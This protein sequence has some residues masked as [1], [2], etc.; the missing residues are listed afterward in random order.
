MPT[1]FVT[2]ATGFIGRH[3][4]ERLLAARGRR[5][6]CS[7]ARAR[8]RSSTRSSRGSAA[9][10]RIQAV[11]GRP[12]R[13][14]CSA[15]PRPTRDGAARQR[16]P[17]LPPR[18]DLRHDRRRGRSNALLNVDGTQHA[19]DARQRP[20]RRA[21]STTPPRSPSPATYQGHFTEDMFDEGQPLP[22]AVPPDEVRV[23][24]ARPRAGR[25]APGAS[26]GR[27]SWSATRARAR[28]TRSTA[29]TTSSRRSRRSRHALPEWFPLVGLEVGWTNIVPVDF[30]AAAM[31]HIAHEP[32]ARRPGVPPR[33]PAPAA[34]RRRAQ[35]VR[36]RRPRAADGHARRQ[37]D[38][39]HA[40][41][42]RPVLRDEAA[43]AQG[44]PAHAARR[45]RHPRRGARAHGA[46]PALRRA[47]HAA[48]AR[49]HR[50]RGA[51]A[52]DLRRRS[53]GTTGSA[54]S[55]PTCSRTA[56][57]RARSTARRS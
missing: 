26:T 52:R 40:A 42:G 53:C 33:Q 49:G 20:R 50:H 47:R 30:V 51:A 18:R 43:G 38:D 39:G 34:R 25:R 19:V 23:R 31:D 32:A 24:E 8:A 37:A 56:R 4:L 5:S 10:D 12:G 3:L 9:S 15:S 16:R 35:H 2:G 1:Y 17:L 7:C 6:T 36:A 22:I 48:R 41:E 14:R 45:P 55:T 54:T 28:W 44:R 21:S 29:R 27:R 46:R 13:S 57:S 11:D